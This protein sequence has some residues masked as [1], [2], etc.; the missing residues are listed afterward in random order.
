MKNDLYELKEISEKVNTKLDFLRNN[1]DIALS[2]TNEVKALKNDIFEK[3]SKTFVYNLKQLIQLEGTQKKLAKKICISEDL[4]S[5][6]KSGEAFP[7]IETLLYI[8]EVYSISLDKLISTP[9]SSADIDNLGDTP[10]NEN[11]IFSEKYY[12]YLLVTNVAME[13]AIHEGLIE[14]CNNNVIFKILSN[15]AVIKYYSGSYTT[16][17]KLVFF[18][19]ESKA[20]GIAYINM[21]RPNININRYVGGLAMLLLPSDANSKPCVQKI[22]FSRIKIDREL[23]CSKLK[24]LLSFRTDGPT[25]GNFKISQ[26]EDELAYNFILKLH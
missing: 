20:D 18:N 25:S 21:I 4:L 2:N 7:S 16:S 15:K 19:L 26:W 24:E 3:T 23:Y 14:L 8:C 1:S 9:L 17:D 11:N 22:L 5:K 13:G 10:E 6:Y 12:I